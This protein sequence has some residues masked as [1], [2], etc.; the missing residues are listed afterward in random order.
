MQSLGQL[1]EDIWDHGSCLAM[2]QAS[3]GGMS[4]S[5]KGRREAGGLGILMPEVTEGWT[6]DFHDPCPA[7]TSVYSVLAKASVQCLF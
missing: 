6:D 4:L 1:A 2:E 3:S 7:C 5:H